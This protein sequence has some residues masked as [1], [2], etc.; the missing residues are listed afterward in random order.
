VGGMFV[1]RQSPNRKGE[2]NSSQFARRNLRI[3]WGGPNEEV[4]G[5]PA[6]RYSGGANQQNLKKL[7]RA[8][9]RGFTDGSVVGLRHGISGQEKE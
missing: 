4:W 5:K 9:T 3:R 6:E 2:K 8:G 7:E 1:Q